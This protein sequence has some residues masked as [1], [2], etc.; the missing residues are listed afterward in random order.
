MYRDFDAC[1]WFATN[2]ISQRF[3]IFTTRTKFVPKVTGVSD[4]ACY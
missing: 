3:E 2:D 1:F 4:L